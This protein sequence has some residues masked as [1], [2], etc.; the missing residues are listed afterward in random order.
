MNH[1]QELP[2]TAMGVLRQLSP[3]KEGIQKFSLQIINQVKGGELNA[4][5]VKAFLK[6]M[7]QI[8]ELVD[9]NTRA[10]QMSEAERYSEKSF[11]VYGCEIQKSEVGVRYD[12]L[13]TGDPIYERALYEFEQAQ[14]KLKE[15][16]EFLKGLKEHMTMVDELTGEVVTVNAP[17]R[18]ATDGLK[19]AIK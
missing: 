10:E 3:T 5:E 11:H 17:L 13:S 12:Y 18:K 8:I 14:K 15:R 7:E 4:L 2:T 16:E 6:A 1:L 19:F 9:K